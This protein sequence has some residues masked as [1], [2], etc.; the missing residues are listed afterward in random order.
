GRHRR[1]ESEVAATATQD[2][3]RRWPPSS[4]VT[5]SPIIPAPIRVGEDQPPPSWDPIPSPRGQTAE[6]TYNYT[7]TQVTDLTQVGNENELFHAEQEGGEEA[8]AGQEED[9]VQLLDEGDD[10]HVHDGG[11]ATGERHDPVLKTSVAVARRN[12][13]E[14]RSKR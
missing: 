4:P 14:T 1:R 11:R 6:G 8:L 12:S 9:D 5:F 2:S 7:S 13:E 3:F 10:I